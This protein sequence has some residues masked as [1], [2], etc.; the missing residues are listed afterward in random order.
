MEPDSTVLHQLYG[1]SFTA[2]V[3][4]QKEGYDLY[5][6]ARLGDPDLGYSAVRCALQHAAEDWGRLLREQSP[7]A[8]VWQMVRD[9]VTEA[10]VHV[11]APAADNLHQRLPAAQ[12]DVE[13][14]HRLGLSVEQAADLMGRAASETVADLLMARRTLRN[15]AGAGDATTAADVVGLPEALR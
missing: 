12:A 14:L 1:S 15:P 2:F 5:A 13:L 4:M 9:C 3:L 11:S 8:C 6:L 7:A 10:R